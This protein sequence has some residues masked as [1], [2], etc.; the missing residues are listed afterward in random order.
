VVDFY[1]ETKHENIYEIQLVLDFLQL[2]VIYVDDQVHVYVNVEYKATNKIK[3]DFLRLKSINDFHTSALFAAN[4]TS[5]ILAVGPF[6]KKTYDPVSSN[7]Q[8]SSSKSS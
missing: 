2:N 8:S 5:I 6:H 3:I 7:I 1:V 4:L